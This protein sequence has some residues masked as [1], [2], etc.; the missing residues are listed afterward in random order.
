MFWFIFFVVFG[1]LGMISIAISIA[2]SKY[3]GIKMINLSYDMLTIA[4][5]CFT[6]TFVFGVIYFHESYI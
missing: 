6:A 3:D 1:A 4:M 5:L 2:F